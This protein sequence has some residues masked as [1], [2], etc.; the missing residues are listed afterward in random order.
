[1]NENLVE[2]FGRSRK[3]IRPDGDEA[4]VWIQPQKLNHK[5]REYFEDAKKHI[6]GGHWL[7]R[8]EVPT[9]SEV[10][11]QDT[12]SSSSS[13]I[14]E[15]VPNKPVGSWESKG[16]SPAIDTSSH[17][18]QANHDYYRGVPQCALRAAS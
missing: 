1:M 12:G 13:D 17:A 3:G 18:Y 6:E 15:I 4:R 10:L 5:V 11:D 7:D 14:V 2:R 9:S 16:E 8:P